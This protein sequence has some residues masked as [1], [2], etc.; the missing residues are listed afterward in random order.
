MKKILKPSIYTPVIN[1]ELSVNVHMLKIFAL[2]QTNCSVC[3]IV[4]L[5]LKVIHVYMS[6]FFK[7]PAFQNYP[8]GRIPISGHISSK[9]ESS[10]WSFDNSWR[11]Y[12]GHNFKILSISETCHQHMPPTCHVMDAADLFP[13]F[14]FLRITGWHSMN[15]ELFELSI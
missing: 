10:S 2:K 8:K 1:Y 9:W 11:L 12:G 6:L 4:R 13:D 5:I 15:F 3:R 14:T 7:N